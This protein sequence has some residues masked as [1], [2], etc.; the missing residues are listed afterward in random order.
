MNECVRLGYACFPAARVR[1]HCCPDARRQQSNRA[2]Q[3]RP[4][5]Q[6]LWVARIRSPRKR[7]DPRFAWL[8][9]G[10]GARTYADR[11]AQERGRR[12]SQRGNGG[13]VGTQ[14]YNICENTKFAS[15]FVPVTRT[16]RSFFPA[17]RLSVTRVHRLSLF[18][19]S[20][21]LNVCRHRHRQQHAA[22]SACA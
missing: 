17:P 4:Q 11:P 3:S 7:R 10:A 14:K 1:S 5:E 8:T 21:A 9:W 16:V 19:P 6:S 20:L 22:P 2:E 13:L 15:H 18:L 12:G